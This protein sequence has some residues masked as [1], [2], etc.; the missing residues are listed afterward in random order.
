MSDLPVNQK[1]LIIVMLIA[2][3]VFS[4]AKPIALRFCAKEDFARRRNT[5]FVLTA[6][7][8]LSPSFWIF[9]AIATPVLLVA[10]RKD[11]APVA[12]YLLLLHVI[13]PISM[14]VPMVGISYLIDINNYLLLSFCVLTPV[15][16]RLLRT[17]GSESGLRLHA[18]D[19]CLIA[20]GLLQAALYLHPE[21][22]DGTLVQ[23]TFTHALRRA[24][25]FFFANFIPYFV[26]SRSSSDR[27]AM[28]DAMAMFCLSCALMAAIAVFETAK[29]W[30]L[31]GEMAYLWGRGSSFSIYLLRNS[32][33]R[34]MASTGHPL[35][36]G[37]LLVVACGFWLYLRQYVESA[38]WRLSVMLLFWVGL[39]ATY[40]RGPWIGAVFLYFAFVLLRPSAFSRTFR[41]VGIAGMVAAVV[42][43]TP[44][45]AKIVS[46]M[47]FLGG[48]VDYGSLVYRQ[49][50]LERAWQ[51]IRDNPLFGDQY[52]LLRMQ[53]LRQGQGIVD[54][55]NTYVQVA[56]ADGLVGLTLFLSFIG[57]GAVKVW[58]ASRSV[59]RADPKL[60]GLG[61][62]LLACILATLLMCWD[63]SF[64][65]GLEQIFYM[66]AGLA[67]AYSQLVRS[68]A[69]G[70]SYARVGPGAQKLT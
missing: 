47:P 64:G 42:S 18:M 51:I 5:W 68:E 56:L 31:Y 4:L 49:L 48:T 1:E 53:D 25:E 26:I 61:V 65:T 12:L 58:M 52:A 21:N 36:L 2:V 33:L 34:A 3:A 29:H 15:A 27:R 16:L 38:P 60:N 50:L 43:L 11:T 40:S 46:L 59:A 10:S 7:A 67:V 28:R 20:Y 13:P 19:W 70:S 22:P 32:S 39:W 24:T 9:A 57:I 55:V 63:G 23:A 62:S 54:V 44:L 35:A 37:S 8:F 41:A 69:L 17:N 6:V 45:G 30:L 66:L 14:R